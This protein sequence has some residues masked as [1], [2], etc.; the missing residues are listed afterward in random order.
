[1]RL[2]VAAIKKNTENVFIVKIQRHMI[3]IIQQE[4]NRG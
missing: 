4:I 2:A 1:M 3:L